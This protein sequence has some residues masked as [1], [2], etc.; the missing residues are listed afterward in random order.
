MIHSFNHFKAPLQETYSDAPLSQ[1]LQNKLVLSNLQNAVTLFIGRRQTS[2]GSPFQV[3]GPT[4]E[5][6]QC[7]LVEVVTQGTKS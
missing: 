5:N 4:M 7:C 2:I 1:L 6:V 3:E